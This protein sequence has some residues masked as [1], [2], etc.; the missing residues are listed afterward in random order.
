M[1]CVT[2]GVIV[3]PPPVTVPLPLNPLSAS[4]VLPSPISF[5]ALAVPLAVQIAEA[6]RQP[7]RIALAAGGGGGGGGGG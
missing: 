5:V 4:F 6:T 1:V 7:A 2:V 3:V